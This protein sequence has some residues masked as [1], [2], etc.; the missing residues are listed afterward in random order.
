MVCYASE[1]SSWIAEP[2]HTFHVWTLQQL[3]TPSYFEEIIWTRMDV[4]GFELLLAVPSYPVQN[5]RVDYLRANGA[6]GSLQ[7]TWVSRALFLAYK[8]YFDD[9]A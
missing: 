8:Q 6:L 4:Q 1:I 2:L 9:I 7:H 5:W 3:V